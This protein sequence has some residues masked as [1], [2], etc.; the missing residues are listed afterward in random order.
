MLAGRQNHGTLEFLFL[1]PQLMLTGRKKCSVR[2]KLCLV[3]FVSFNV[4]CSY[5]I[6]VRI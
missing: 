4:S 3:C 1:L 6:A 5:I 2:A